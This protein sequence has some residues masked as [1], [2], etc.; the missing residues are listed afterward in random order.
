[1]P[2]KRILILFN[3]FWWNASAYYTNILAEGLKDRDYQIT[4]CG[5]EGT[6]SL[7]KIASLNIEH[8]PLPYNTYSPI[9]IVRTIRQLKRIIKKNNID[10]VHSLSSQAH[11]FGSAVIKFLNNN[12]VHIRSCLDARPPVTNLMNRYM[13]RRLTDYVTFPCAKTRVFYKSAGL[14]SAEKSSII[15]SGLNIEAFLNY[16]K[17][18]KVK[19]SNITVGL[20]GRLSPEKGVFEFLEIMNLV[21]KKNPD[22][23]YFISGKEEQITLEQ[24]RERAKSLGIFKNG[25]FSSRADDVRDIL[26]QIDIGVVTSRFSEVIPR[27]P[28]EYM[29]FHIPVVATDVNVL[30]ETIKNGSSGFIY[31]KDNP[32]GMADGILKLAESPDKRKVFG[33]AGFERVKNLFSSAGMVKKYIELYNNLETKTRGLDI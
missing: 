9:K 23:R 28:L 8:Y 18:E 2:K 22:I 20:I 14:I 16:K 30:P 15:Y 26:V 29:A 31:D 32:A 17:K 6:P 13:H 24:I 33:D 11:F 21:L 25:L 3:S 12:I 27:V 1:M 7:E 10:I 4:F 19:N 5:L